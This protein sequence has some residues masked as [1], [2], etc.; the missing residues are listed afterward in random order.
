MDVDSDTPETLMP[1][2]G[3][4]E[5]FI[6]VLRRHEPVL[7]TYLLRFTDNEAVVQDLR[8]ETYLEAYRSLATYRR[9]GS[10]L[11]WLRRIASR[12]GYRYWAGRAKEERAKSAYL[13][14]LRGCAPTDSAY[15]AQDDLERVRTFLDSLDGYDRI[16]LEMKYLEGFRSPEIARRL[17]WSEVRVRVRRHRALKRLRGLHGTRP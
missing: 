14:L 2:Q 6:R 13:E 5:S 16:L 11:N 4:E 8:Q 15:C 10:F 17:G 1:L 9:E 3:D 12:V 7:S